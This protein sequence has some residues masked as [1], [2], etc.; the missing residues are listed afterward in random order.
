MDPA[1]TALDVAGRFLSRRAHS[2]AELRSKLTARGFDEEI[3]ERTL[4]KLASLKVVD[5]AA[6][7][8]DWVEERATRKGIGSRRLRAELEAKGIAIEE[9]DAVL[10]VDPDEELTRAKSLAADRVARLANLPLRKQGARLFSW[11]VGRGFE[12]EIAEAAARSVLPPEG[13]D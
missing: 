5:D 2:T 1:R 9:V 6:F 7:A 3:V 11:L 13:W 4:E 8:K 10:V 12:E